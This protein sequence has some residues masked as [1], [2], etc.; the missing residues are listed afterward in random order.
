MSMSYSNNPQ[1]P[2]VRA[3]AVKMV[4]DGHNVRAVAWHFGYSHSA[5]VTWC[6]K[7]HPEQR[8]FFVIPTES[9][10]PSTHPNTLNEAIIDRILKN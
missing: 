10:R 2:R 1:L 9:S 4:R 7:V 5:I 6:Q 3:E 8:Q